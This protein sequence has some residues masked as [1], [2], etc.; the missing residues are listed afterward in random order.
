MTKVYVLTAGEYSDYHVVG[1]FSTKEEAEKIGGLLYRKSVEAEEYELDRMVG[2]ER[3]P[4]FVAA[5]QL[6]DGKIKSGKHLKSDLRHPSACEVVPYNDSI[7]VISPI[8]EA[9][10][11]KVAIEERQKKLRE[12]L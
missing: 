11:R 12:I 8:S 9:H 10:A 1:V 7:D 2:L 5:I 4:T 6:K 3:G